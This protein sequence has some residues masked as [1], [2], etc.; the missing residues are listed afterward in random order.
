[1]SNK[2]AV[3]YQMSALKSDCS[4]FS[5]LY[6]SCQVRSGD[7]EEFFSHENQNY[8]PSLS[9]QGHL[10]SGT[11]SDLVG[12]LEVLE[13][14][15]STTKPQVDVVILDGAAVVHILKPQGQCTFD[16]YSK[17][18]FCPYIC[19]NMK[20]VSRLDIVWDCYSVSSLKGGCRSR[21]G[22]GIR[23]RVEPNNK[24][25][26]NWNDFL[27]DERNKEELFV[28][29]AKE[30]MN[31]SEE[32]QIVSTCK[33]DVISREERDVSTLGPCDHEEADTRIFLHMADAIQHGH[34]RFMV[35]TVDT[36]VVVLAVAACSKHN[37]SELWVAYGVGKG[38]RYLGA[39]E[40]ARA[41]GPAKAVSLP[42]FHAFTGCDTVS[43][44]RGKGKKSAWQTWKSME[45]VTQTFQN[46]LND[47]N[48]IGDNIAA[49]ECY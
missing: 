11:K 35:R 33:N 27:Q 25:P 7:L 13:D 44:F 8:P 15:P 19:T 28:F 39:H 2:S 29:L 5:R 14:C 23:R 41:L 46:L 24:I 26:K 10:N 43:F 32:G 20:G 34:S 40:I 47:P 9:S 38:F 12:C 45:E 6:V 3:S 16:D 21:R 42:M 1:M 17:E 18:V 31:V 22:A 37:I 36:D 49:I 48:S 4:L 30:S